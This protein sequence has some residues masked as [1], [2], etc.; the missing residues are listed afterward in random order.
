MRFL[1]GL[2][3]ESNDVDLL[4]GGL[5]KSRY[6]K[7]NSSMAATTNILAYFQVLFCSISLIIHSNKAIVTF[8]KQLGKELQNIVVRV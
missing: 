4:A 5:S 7:Y 6:A 2:N 8:S 3:M 1:S